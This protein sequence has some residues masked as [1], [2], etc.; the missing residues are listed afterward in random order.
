MTTFFRPFEGKRPYVF[1]SYSH[2]DTERVLSII[3]PLHDGKLRLWYDE[4]IPAGNDWSSNIDAHM[5]A[6]GAVLFFRSK[7]A[8]ASPNCFSEIATAVAE[9]RPLLIVPLD[10]APID[11]RWTALLSK[12]TTIDLKNE[13]DDAAILSGVRNARILGRSFYR[14]RGENIRFDR[15]GLFAALLFMALTLAVLYGI[16]TGRIDPFKKTAEVP[17]TFAPTPTPTPTPYVT[18]AP[19]PAPT[20]DVSGYESL[21]PVNFGGSKLLENA[22]RAAIGKSSGGVYKSELNGVTE[23]FLCGHMHLTDTSDVRFDADGTCRVGSG[24]VI[25]GDVTKL[26]VISD[27]PYLER[28]ALIRQ[29]L[30]DL[31]P[32]NGHVVLEELWLSGSSVESIEALNDLPQLRSLHLEHTAVTDLTGLSALPALSVVTVSIDMLPLNLEPDA[33]YIVRV[34]R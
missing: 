9:N 2:R 6:C 19:S 10:D 29:P 26:S 32:L 7:T 3:K 22:V 11:E 30:S 5:R 16:L 20:P 4:G 14:R 12:G 25:E 24:A 23:L 8:L 15:M 31:S 34:V 33:P 18:E 17:A 21:L 1:I 27:M 28:L 13:A